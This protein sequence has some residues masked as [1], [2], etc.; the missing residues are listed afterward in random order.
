ML[1]RL[2]R[3]VLVEEKS[4][5]QCSTGRSS[6]SFSEFIRH[7]KNADNLWFIRLITRVRTDKAITSTLIYIAKNSWWVHKYAID[8]SA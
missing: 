1:E 5:L 8:I 6:R 2:S 3:R 7:H 4:R